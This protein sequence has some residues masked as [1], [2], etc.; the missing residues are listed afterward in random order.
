MKIALKKNFN[1]NNF[2]IFVINFLAFQI[3]YIEI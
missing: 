1:K 2:Y 3:L